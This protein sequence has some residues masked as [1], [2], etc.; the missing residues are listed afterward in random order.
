[1]TA[2]DLLPGQSYDRN[3]VHERY[4][5]QRQYGISTPANA[6]HILLFCAPS[7]ESYGYEDGWREDGLFRYSGEGQ[8][9]DMAFKRGNDAILHHSRR[10]KKLHLFTSVGTRRVHY[11]GEFEYFDHEIVE[12]RDLDGNTRKAIMFVLRPVRA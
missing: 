12:S 10:G 8:R 6:S 5:G 9:G 1:M 11:E 4:G 7:A 2:F 3:N